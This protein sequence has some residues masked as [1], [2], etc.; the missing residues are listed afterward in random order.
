MHKMDGQV[1]VR[2][3]LAPSGCPG[4]RSSS[5][6][7]SNESALEAPSS[8]CGPPASSGRPRFHRH[9]KASTRSLTC[10]A[11]HPMPVP[12]P[13]R[14][15][16]VRRQC[17]CLSGLLPAQGTQFRARQIGCVCL[18]FNSPDACLCETFNLVVV[19]H[20]LVQERA[21]RPKIQNFEKHNLKKGSF[22]QP[23]ISEG[24]PKPRQS[25]STC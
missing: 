14:A 13:A 8:A 10:G 7:L 19:P 5:P 22:K 24:W 15:G 20:E 21:V 6:T 12:Q 17:K 1:S 18:P 2:R 9:S 3:L 25:E 16:G 23:C 11:T 4:G